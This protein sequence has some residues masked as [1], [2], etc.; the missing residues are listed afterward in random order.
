MLTKI[1]SEDAIYD[2]LTFMNKK[3]MRNASNL[4]SSL[5]LLLFKST[6]EREEVTPRKKKLCDIACDVLDDEC[7][8]IKKVKM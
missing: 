3:V 6:C 4:K 8:K 1:F 2:F 5:N 7:Y